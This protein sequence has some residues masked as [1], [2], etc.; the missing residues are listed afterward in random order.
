[1][2]R[3]LPVAAVVALLFV[4]A[5]L[6]FVRDFSGDFHWH[7]VLGNQILDEHAVVK[8]DTFSHTF[9]GQPVLVTSWLG[10]LLL[11]LSFRAGEYAGCYG[12]RALCLIAS[13]GLLCRE[14]VARGVHATTAAAILTAI[15]A[16]VM[17]QLYLRPELFAVVAFAVLL[18]A[19]GS[20]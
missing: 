8:Y 18:H 14:M 9:A 1:M 19:L 2:R 4:A 20:H 10:D 16:Q 17:F 15:L 7:V 6:G 12:L 5:L 13:V 3:A 11:A